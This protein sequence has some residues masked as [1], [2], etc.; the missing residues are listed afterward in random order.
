MNNNDGIDWNT[1][2]EDEEVSAQGSGTFADFGEEGDEYSQDTAWADEPLSEAGLEPEETFS[3]TQGKQMGYKT[4]AIIIAVLLA[5]GVLLLMFMDSLSIKK[6]PAVEDK[7]QK[8]QEQLQQQGQVEEP[9]VDEPEDN[10]QG[11]DTQK[12]Q[13]QT[14]GGMVE[15]PADTALN[16]NSDVLSASGVVHDRVRYLENTQVV[17]CVKIVLSFGTSQQLVNYYCGYDVY[18]SISEGDVVTVKYQQVS[19]SVFSVCN[20]AK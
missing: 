19:D 15:L 12:E 18:N 10:N 5:V 14:S 11:A 7:S 13:P 16:Y 1:T 4:V 20:I 17:Y 9:V 2:S 8:Q 3:P 6:K